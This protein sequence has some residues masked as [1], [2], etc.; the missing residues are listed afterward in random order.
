[1]NSNFD[2]LIFLSQ[3]IKNSNFQSSSSSNSSP[4]NQDS[5]Q[6]QLNLPIGITLGLIASFI[7]SI[8]LTIQ[9]KSHLQNQK[10]PL[11]KRKPDYSRPIWL[12]GFTIYFTFNI[13]GSIFQIGTLP[14]IILGPLG[15]I[16]LLWNAILA[17]LLLNDK[18]SHHLILGT[19][20]IALGALLIASFGLLPN[21]N[22]YDLNHL[23][24][25]YSRPA[26]LIE[27]GFL[28]LTFFL[29]C[30]LAHYHEFHLNHSIDSISLLTFSPRSSSSKSLSS[31][32]IH[33]ISTTC[34]SSKS[35]INPNHVINHSNSNQNSQSN[36]NLNSNLNINS[37][38]NSNQNSQSN[39]T[40][41]NLSLNHPNLTQFNQKSFDNL[42]SIK[43]PHSIDFKNSS[44][45]KISKQKLWIGIAYGSTS[46][47][48]SGIC[49][50]FAKTG[51]ELL[52][53]T[54]TGPVNEF[55]K[56][57]SWL[58]LLILL[59]SAL[60]Q[61]WYLN[62]ALR[63]VNPTLICPLAFCFYN[64]SSI[65]SS[66]VYYDQIKLLSSIQI[67][68]ISIGTLILL[69]GVWI[70]SLGTNQ[71]SNTFQ[72]NLNQDNLSIH[73]SIQD[74]IT[75]LLS[76]N[77]RL[78]SCENQIN[79]VE[80]SIELDS[81]LD[82][83][84]Q[85]PSRRLDHSNHQRRSSQPFD[86]LIRQFLAEGEI[87]TVRGFSIG[88][89]AASPGFAIRPTKRRNELRSSWPSQSKK[90]DLDQTDHHED[91]NLN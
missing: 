87:S 91:S 29:I 7:Q 59:I 42:H 57:Q 64:L 68:A 3:I 35:S 10:L 20:L 76:S 72:Q 74:E 56:F 70:V 13:L 2:S 8:G 6:S 5:H 31:N 38:S 1:M 36:S 34:S 77:S 85:S 80:P 4:S 22:S 89:G 33:S 46:G 15:A 52:I 49:L 62:K 19:I 84:S 83:Q 27:I 54:L 75:P 73:S 58:I 63:L 55:K 78:E 48:L 32:S 37:I 65:I 16:S 86:N 23:I 24:F 44:N 53:K 28:S 69:A 51:V 43:K 61:L 88:L 45:Q 90:S 21:Q 41:I 82:N 11:H 50:L 25:L 40:Q 9:R 12:I 66:L 67:L 47:T 71:N 18:F 39:L 17:K 60:L 26:F 30:S 14:L 79:L 81:S